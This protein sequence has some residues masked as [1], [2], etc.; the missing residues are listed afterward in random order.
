MNATYL[1]LGSTDGYQQPWDLSGCG[2]S[3]GPLVSGS[4][5]GTG[6]MGA[7]IGVVAV[8]ARPPADPAVTVETVP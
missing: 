3:S 5:T 4:G 1:P 8:P 2:V 7:G 6:A